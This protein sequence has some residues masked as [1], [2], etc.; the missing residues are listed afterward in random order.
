MKQEESVS[1]E[2]QQIST[3]DRKQIWKEKSSKEAET[4]RRKTEAHQFGELNWP[5]LEENDEKM[6][7]EETLNHM[8]ILFEYTQRDVLELLDDMDEI[9][10]DD[11]AE[12]EGEELE[13]EECEQAEWKARTHISKGTTIV[14]PR[15]NLEFG[16]L[17]CIGADEEDG[18][19][20]PIHRLTN[21]YEA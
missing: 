12:E 20:A 10:L 17:W 8:Q 3:K 7:L 15:R 1:G 21:V 18:K 19:E 13:E 14:Y 2:Q 4:R 9:D 6:S 5:I 11:Y 16:S